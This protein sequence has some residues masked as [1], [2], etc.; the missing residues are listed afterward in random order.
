MR[1]RVLALL[2]TSVL[3]TLPTYAQIDR[4]PVYDGL[5]DKAGTPTDFVFSPAR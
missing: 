2:F 4:L 5:V 1:T 3:A